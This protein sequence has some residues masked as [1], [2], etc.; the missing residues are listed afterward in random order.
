MAGAPSHG[1]V[2]ANGAAL[3]PRVNRR[4]DATFVNATLYGAMPRILTTCEATG[5]TVP[6]GHRTTDLELND[7]TGPRNFRCP[8]CQEV[9]A[10]TRD[11]AVIEQRLT[12]AAFRAAAA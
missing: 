11:N 7:V 2:V 12:L 10:W 5:Q 1:V 6:T 9:H 8:A 4:L 3:G